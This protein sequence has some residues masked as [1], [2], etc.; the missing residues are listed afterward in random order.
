M[1]IKDYTGKE[2]A[3]NILNG[4]AIGTVIALVPGAL[5][6]TPL[7]AIAHIWPFAVTLLQGITLLNATMGLIIGITVA[8]FFKFTPI[9]M[10]SVGMVTFFACGVGKFVPD[11]NFWAL[12]GTGDVITMGIIAAIAVFWI[13]LIADRVRSYAILV[14]PATTFLL[15]GSIGVLLYPYITMITVAVGHGVAY[16]V[17]LKPF[18]MSILISMV[19]SILI[20]SPITSVGVAL[21]IGISGI[22][23]GAANLGVCT[24]AFGFCVAGWK[25]NTVGTSLAHWLGAPKISMANIVAKPKIM[26]PILCSAAVVGLLAPLLNIQGSPMSAGFGFSGLVGPVAAIDLSPAGWTF[27][28][29][30]YLIG[31]FALAPT[32]VNIV[33]QYLFVNVLKIIKPEDYYLELK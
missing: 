28:N 6:T 17:T 18:L 30:L 12:R 23:S 9:Q 24:A 21:A 1:S 10:G 13:L 2:F 20:M 8:T 32:V 22:A 19:F 27:F 3:M 29:A 33:F 16:L 11:G 26:L 14:I 31:L 4:V 15:A 25:V 7:R 5:L